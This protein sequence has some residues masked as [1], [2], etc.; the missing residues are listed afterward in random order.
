MEDVSS[1][2][3]FYTNR[4]RLQVLART[5]TAVTSLERQPVARSMFTVLDKENGI[6]YIKRYTK[7][8]NRIYYVLPILKVGRR[9]TNPR[10]KR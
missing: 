4:E 1:K 8:C 10:A 7:R 6:R 9:R 5:T 3:N 2:G